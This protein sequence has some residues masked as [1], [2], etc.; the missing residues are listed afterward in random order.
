MQKSDAQE[1]IVVMSGIQTGMCGVSPH[2]NFTPAIHHTEQHLCM[3]DCPYMKLN[4][5]KPSPGMSEVTMDKLR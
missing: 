1:F 2:T 4:T 3:Y 5:R